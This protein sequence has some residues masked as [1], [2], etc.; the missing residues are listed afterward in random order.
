MTV[1]GSKYD[2]KAATASVRWE[3]VAG[4]V[5]YR[6]R[7]APN[8]RFSSWTYL[9]P[10]AA[11]AVPADT[12]GGSKA[13][14]VGDL[15][16]AP[17]FQLPD[18]PIGG[19]YLVE[20]AAAV[21][22]DGD[23]AA[24]LQ[25][26]PWA[27]ASLDTTTP[28]DLI[29]VLRDSAAAADARMAEALRPGM[30]AK[31]NLDALRKEHDTLVAA[32]RTLQQSEVAL[33]LRVKNAEVRADEHKREA[34]RVAAVAAAATDD[35]AAA[36]RDA[37]ATLA[38]AKEEAAS[39]S[40]AALA[41]LRAQMSMAAEE[42]ANKAAADADARMRSAVTAAHAEGETAK[43]A[44]VV[45]AE[46]PLRA[47]CDRLAAE[48]DK[49]RERAEAAE[50]AHTAAVEAA[51]AGKAAEVADITAILTEVRAAA[52]ASAASAAAALTDA[53]NAA[54]AA[55]KTAATALE[56]A[57]TAA[58]AATETAAR[59]FADERERAA[60]AQRAALAAAAAETAT[61][62]AAARATSDATTAELRTALA[63]ATAA[64]DA[65]AAEVSR[66]GGELRIAAAA[67]EAAEG[68][69]VTLEA[70]VK[71]AK[72]AEEAV[73]VDLA[74]AREEAGQLVTQVRT[75]VG[76]TERL[77]GQVN[78]FVERANM[79]AASLCANG[80][81]ATADNALDVASAAISNL[82]K[83]VR[84][85]ESHAAE[86]AFLVGAG[87]PYGPSGGGGAG[88]AAGSAPR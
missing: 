13:L 36:R 28:E 50:K 58:A 41:Q 45:A 19:A 26:T 33:A 6:V 40:A 20:V 43:A 39:A 85:L 78:A 55:A 70:T 84:T 87:N 66:L 63:A 16:A 57:R 47:Q 54:A 61:A 30:E 34:E 21:R 5:G 7:W 44:A 31:T 4:A 74:A 3:A 17:A 11:E 88:G 32:H 71:A 77:T 60:A 18:L 25:L 10:N 29:T 24:A 73:G 83:R 8:S 15:F 23:A 62:V 75:L 67:R 27:P 22:P 51:T 38:A 65:A 86:D 76:H 52:A 59:A 56:E 64:R 48:L 53:Q 12:P 14:A 37:A 2:V 49:M 35:A 46:A 81:T 68:K 1:Q 80:L 79:M 42:A 9:K 69:V 72:E 82:T